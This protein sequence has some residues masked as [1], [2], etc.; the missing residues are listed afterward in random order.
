VTTPT[1]ELSFIVTC[2][3]EEKSIEEFHARLSRTV[4]PLGRSFEIVMVNDGST[5]G[6]FA[7]LEGFFESDSR[8]TTVIDLYRNAGQVAAMTA[9]ITHARG[10]AMIFMDSDLQLDPE[11]LPLLLDEFDRG[12][13]IVSGVRRER[14]DSTFR[15]VSSRLANVVMR[16]VS[17]HP[18][19]DFGCTYKIYDARLLRAFEFGPFKTFRTA[20]VF[21][22]AK[23]VKE[24][25]IT[26]HERRYGRSGWNFRKLFAFYMDHLV[27]LSERP[28]QF[29]SVAFLLLAFVLGLRLVL[30]WTLQITILPEVTPGL[31]LNVL[32]AGVLLVLGVLCLIG[33]Y[34]MRN[35]LVL[36]RYPAYIIRQIRQKAQP[37]G[38]PR[39]GSE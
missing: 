33:E 13:D 12:Y 18:L 34:V 38:G 1:P 20:Y 16:R 30:A 22:R 25:S 39:P 11:E 31:I 4:Q 29:L 27:G 24:V 9:G 21:A 37:A 8:V 14:H 3:F 7:K 32:V 28:F 10:D 36:Q 19:T 5:D 15:T 35:F 17:G 26:H 23:R 6:T 2:Y